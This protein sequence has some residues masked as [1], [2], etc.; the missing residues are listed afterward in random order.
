M[1]R[2]PAKR[3]IEQVD[4]TGDGDEASPRTLPSKSP[5]TPNGQRF[6]QDTTFVPPSQSSQVYGGEDEDDAQAADLI[7]GSQ[8]V[9]DSSIGTYIHYGDLQTKIVGVR[10]YRGHA[11]I[12]EHV[13]IQRDIGNAYD[14]N[15]IRVSNVMGAQI[16]HI[17][18]TMA[19]KLAKYMDDRSL[20]VEGVLTGVIGVYDCPISLKLF[21]TNHPEARQA[22]KSRMEAD[23]LPLGAFKQNERNERNRQKEREKA[24]KD[25]A[26]LARSLA[27]GKDQ[28]WQAEN[29]FGYSNLFTGEGLVEGQ[30]LEELI[31]QSSAFN[32]RDIGQVAEDFGMKESDLENMP[33][34]ETPAAL[35]TQLLP[36]QRQGLAWM[37]AKENP[38][39]PGD[40]G[41]VVQ[42]WKKNG[43]KYTNIATNYSMSQAPPLAS[44]GILADDM[45]LGKTIQIISLIL[46][47]SQPKTP[48]SSSTT[49]I[50]SPVGVMSNWRNQARDHT[51]SDKAPKVLIYHGQGKKEAGN[52]DQYD[53]VVTSYGALAMEYSPNAKAPPK[54]GLFSVHWR[55]VVLDEG[56]TIRNPRSKGS[57]AACNLRAGSRWTLTGTPIINTLK[58]LYS[59]VRFLRLSGGLE[60]LAVF[61]S[62]LIRP[63]VSGDP[64]ARLLLQALMTTIC[65]RRRK[66][67]N[68]VNL[69]LPPL[70]SRILRVK[71]H[72][73]EQEKYDLFQSEAKGMLLDFKNKDKTTATYSHLLEVILRLRQVCNHWALCKNRLDKLSD[74]LENNK[75]VPLTPENIK[76]LQDLLQ[77]RIE[78]QD[79]CPICLDNLEQPVITACAHAFD[80]GCI[81]QVIERQHKCPMCRAEIQDT[82]TLVSPAVEMGE[83][84]DTVVAD[85]DNPSSKIEALIK[86]LTAQGQAPGTKTVVFSQ[87]TSFLNLVEPHLQ[88]HGIGFARIDGKMTSINRDNSTLRFSTDPT[89]TVLLASLSVCSVGLNLV[90]ANQAILADSWWAPAIEDQAVD[91]VHRLGQKRETTVWRLIME[92][93]IEDRVLAIQ[94]NKR[95]LMLEAFRETATKKKVDDRATRV[96]DL[97]TLLN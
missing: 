89:C 42:L 87:W 8:D 6:G 66:D 76:A 14:S 52:L 44:G 2:T 25:A 59:Q 9:D 73:H 45:G 7:Q 91:R 17:P 74:L 80:R 97:E 41:D 56:H 65:L 31:G 90:A 26:K 47:N 36:Y 63:L 82:S 61:N 92:D 13:R 28:Q 54:K 94:E 16:G 62:V 48:E 58:D 72:P 95:K 4:L 39:L 29:V 1:G 23:R 32:P 24:M 86:I 20:V 38:S 69:R 49:L 83:S 53:V 64:D 46:A 43:N 68:F 81:E 19:A 85:P 88:R 22:L 75:V 12:G 10:Y 21:G 77:I 93:S 30:N 78:S 35:A 3:S 71:F 55:R 40:G 37:T 50:V 70:T 79:T 18:R 5:R 96:A 84:V 51:H 60:D 27:K 15:A 11:T 33:M 34:A 67:M 57:L